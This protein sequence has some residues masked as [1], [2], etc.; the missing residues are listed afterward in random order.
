MCCT[1]LE[2]P[3]AEHQVVFW[4]GNSPNWIQS[5]YSNEITGKNDP[6]LPELEWIILAL[7]A[8]LNLTGKSVYSCQA[9]TI[10]LSTP[11]QLELVKSQLLLLMLI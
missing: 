8:G 2:T 11:C 6:M 3:L 7:I 5:K 1:R 4:T 10:I 9:S